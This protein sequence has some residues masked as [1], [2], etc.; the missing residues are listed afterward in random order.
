MPRIAFAIV[1]EEVPLESLEGDHSE[2]PRWHDP[3]GIDVVAAKRKTPAA[4]LDDAV[5]RG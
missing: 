3:I 5:R 2:I 1:L 4:D